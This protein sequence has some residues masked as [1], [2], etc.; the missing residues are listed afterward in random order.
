MNRPN[1][2]RTPPDDSHR[3]AGFGEDGGVCDAG[4][5]ADFLHVEDDVVGVFL[6]AVVDGG[7]EVGL[8]AVVV[9][10]ES[11]AD[12]DHSEAGAEALQFGVHAN[13][14]D[15]G[16]LHVADVVDLAAEVEVQQVEAVA[17]AVLAEEVEGVDDFGDEQAE[18]G[19]HAAGLFPRARAAGGQVQSQGDGRGDV[20]LLG[21]L[22]D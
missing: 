9:N 3:P 8:G 4:L 13:E 12:V 22:H 19:T 17:H 14:L 21:V 10:T 20:M 2:E 15:G 6:E 1:L 18:L 16:G 11:A 5:V 7:F